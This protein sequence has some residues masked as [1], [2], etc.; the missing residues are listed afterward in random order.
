MNNKKKFYQCVVLVSNGES[1]MMI[2][3]GDIFSDYSYTN[4]DIGFFFFDFLETNEKIV[5]FLIL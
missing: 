5:L 2:L 3:F 4:L 1:N